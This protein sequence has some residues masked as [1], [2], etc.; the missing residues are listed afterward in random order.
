MSSSTPI[1]NALYLTNLLQALTLPHRMAII[2]CSAHTGGSVEISRG[3]ALANT[4]AHEWACH[5]L[6]VVPSEQSVLAN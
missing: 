5:F 3:N 6:N 4:S 1:K 2:K